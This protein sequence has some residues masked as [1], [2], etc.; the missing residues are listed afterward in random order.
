LKLFYFWQSNISLKN[1]VN[2]KN[3]DNHKN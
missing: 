2:R 1:I 3:I